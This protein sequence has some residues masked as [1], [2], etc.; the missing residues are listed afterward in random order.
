[1]I[2][3]GYKTGKTFG[4]DHMRKS[5]APETCHIEMNTQSM[6]RRIVKGRLKL[7]SDNY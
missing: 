5:E 3:R 4:N 7:P 1:M 2:R 6:G